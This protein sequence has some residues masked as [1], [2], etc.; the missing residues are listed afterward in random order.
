MDFA[1][2]GR[3]ILR[4]W[5]ITAPLMLLTVVAVIWAMFGVPEQA[6]VTGHVTLLPQREQYSPGIGDTVTTNPWSPVR[7]ADVISVRLGSPALA[8]D[9]FTQGYRGEWTVTVINTG[10]A[11]IAIEVL[12]DSEAD[13]RRVI[14]VM[15][16]LI[17][18]EVVARQESLGLSE[19]AKITV[20]PLT[21]ADLVE[22]DSSARRR[23]AILAAGAGTVVTL[24][25]AALLEWLSRRRLRATGGY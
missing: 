25:G 13:A 11:I 6:K 8:D 7:L 10:A 22:Q 2:V 21:D 19:G 18:E 15:D 3:I 4:R 20:V 12:A 17:T 9:L 16:S 24:A 14:D 5:P 23:I 1:D